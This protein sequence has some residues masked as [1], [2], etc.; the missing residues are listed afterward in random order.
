MA[1]I[2]SPADC[3]VNP[4]EPTEH[5]RT[6][7]RPIHQS[8][9]IPPIAED[10]MS[11]G[12]GAEL[13]TTMQDPFPD[14]PTSHVSLPDN[15]S[16]FPLVSSSSNTYPT[17]PPSDQQDSAPLEVPASSHDA[18]ASPSDRSSAGQRAPRNLPFRSPTPPP[19]EPQP[20]SQPQPSNPF[21]APLPS[22]GNQR[23]TPSLYPSTTNLTNRTTPAPP[24]P[25][26]NQPTTPA[27]NP[28]PS[29]HPPVQRN[30]RRRRFVHWLRR[31]FRRQLPW[32]EGWL[33]RREGSERRE[34][35]MA[36][37]AAERVGL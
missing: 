13:A 29:H 36:I 15:T 25:Q 37:K 12:V 17:R 20:Q 27:S 23:A 33:H 28:H 22:Y 18:S 26:T 8:S 24:R 3:T 21:P 10:R 14:H 4:E 5:I 31:R 32:L 16:E 34:A 35:T 11:D 7:D 19:I 1:T 30:R 9:S 6:M 2:E